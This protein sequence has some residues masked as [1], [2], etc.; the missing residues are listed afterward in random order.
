[1][2]TDQWNWLWPD[3]KR[4]SAVL[5]NDE[6]GQRLLALRT[7]AQLGVVLLIGVLAASN[8]L[9]DLLRQDFTVS[10]PANAVAL[11]L[12]MGYTLYF[13]HTRRMPELDYFILLCCAM[14]VGAAWGRGF[15]PTLLIGPVIALIYCVLYPKTALI[16]SVGFIVAGHA[17]F[18][19]GGHVAEGAVMQRLVMGQFVVLLA[20]HITMTFCMKLVFDLLQNRHAL[21][22]ATD[23]K[24]RF[25]SA[26]SHEL[27]T[28]LNGI[29][30]MIYGLRQT[31]LSKAQSEFVHDLEISS[32]HLNSLVSDVLDFAR[33]E[34]NQ[35][36]I[37]MQPFDIRA[38]LDS[39][40][41]M[42]KPAA[43][44]KG[45]QYLS[46]MD[47][48]CPLLWVADQ[49]RLIQSLVNLMNNAVKFTK[50]GT[51]SLNVRQVQTH[52]GQKLLRFTVSDTG[53]G[54]GVQGRERLF[55]PFTQANEDTF[56]HYGGTGLGL[57]LCREL[58]ERMGGHIDFE[59]T[60]G[61]GSSFWIDLAEPETAPTLHALQQSMVTDQASQQFLPAG[62][63][64]LVVD[65]APINRKV[66]TIFL[67]KLGVKTLLA[68]DGQQGL[69]EIK[70]H[71][72]H[73]DFV[74]MDVHMPTMTGLE[75]TQAIRALAE[76]A[77]VPVIGLTGAALDSEV[78]EALASGMD[79]VLFKPLDPMA[80]M[81]ALQALS[82]KI[83]ARRNRSQAM[84]L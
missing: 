78:K 79:R 67:N 63:T 2:A 58:V 53:I 40:S 1:M 13:L 52:A 55:K 8:I 39:V 77:D 43:Q 54:I 10:F 23:A 38:V 41:A 19:L 35:L 5:T 59:S 49:R 21:K 60:P 57:A 71:G 47:E 24:S 7:R 17:A 80:L 48:D 50:Q 62:M 29:Q 74:L 70:R 65:D 9:G 72:A 42:I 61:L 81:N 3:G 73:L 75:A 15:I 6:F 76:Y 31:S 83:M 28:P 46:T 16:I 20:V 4:V 11:A 66:A 12:S 68:C 14:V 82:P 51:V 44:A 33:L 84:N 30:G 32:Q 22:Q 25:L 56:V 26:V 36:T 37:V 64:G 18:V 45:L 27:R 69:E 34:A